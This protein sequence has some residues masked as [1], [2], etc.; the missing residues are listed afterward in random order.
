[1]KAQV[2]MKKCTHGI[3][4]KSTEQQVRI[5]SGVVNKLEQKK[6]QGK[7]QAIVEMQ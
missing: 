3:S 7:I 2:K 6:D 1:M 4:N 5:A